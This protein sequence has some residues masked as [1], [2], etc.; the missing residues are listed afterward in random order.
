MRLRS[1]Q[2]KKFRN[3][4]DSGEIAVEEW[5]TCLVGK[6]EAGKSALLEALYLLNPAYDDTFNV[7]EQYPRWLA[8]EDRRQGDLN[9]VTPISVRLELE[10]H[11]CDEVV[12]ALGTGVLTSRDLKVSKRYGG[13]WSWSLAWSEEVAVKNL[14]G[15]F[16][17][18]VAGAVREQATLDGLKEALGAL[19]P[20]D[21][22]SGP[23]DDEIGAARAVLADKGLDTTGVW[24]RLVGIL[25]PHLPKFFRFTEYSTL[26]GRIDFEELASGRQE[27]PGRSGLQTARALLE[28][29]GTQ[30]DQLQNDDYELR[31]GELEAVQIDL[32]N[33]VFE[34]WKQNP[35]L[36]VVIDVDKET[37]QHSHGQTAVARF[38]DIRLS[39]GRTGYSNNF[40][41]R[42]SGFQWFFSFL[43]AFSEFNRH[44]APVVLLDEPAL[45]LHGRAQADFLRFI[46]QRLAPDS[47][48]LYT[49]HS[50][51]M[52]EAGSLERVRIVEDSGPPTGATATT[53]VLVA[54]PDSLFPLQAA[55]G[56][57]IA[58]SLF[59]GPNNLVV[60]GTSDFIYLTIMSQLCAAS[61]RSRLDDRWR[62]LPAG[63]ATNIPTFVSLIGPH[64]DITVLADAGTKGMQRVTGMVNQ[65]LLAGHRLILAS[66]AAVSTNADIE[67]LFSEGDYLKLFN[68]TF[69]T[70]LTVSNLPQG[71]R[72]VKRLEA[73]QGD[74]VH[75]EVAE[76]LLR[77]HSDIPF[78]DT[79]LDRFATLIDAINVTMG[80]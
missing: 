74:Y 59:I 27:G 3:V 16:P 66:A 62:V 26:P 46:N 61:G 70:S 77:K 6:N 7:E 57:D 1:F 69:N 8:V 38:L 58:Q 50:P 5:V 37:V 80:A 34:Y 68:K 40:S 20:A 31:R 13:R 15:E 48:V 9:D 53:E 30:L 12:E 39:D 60:E 41:Q 65:G 23:S 51:F 17:A 18:S 4:V 25:K 19:V 32:T 33:Q 71:D 56:Y 28:L 79:T 47:P 21:E 75:G 42:S 67:D 63:G 44:D 14:L 78:T 36:K 43:A 72:I 2:V 10:D 45:T 35:D 76:T 73:K 22:G 52:V 49:T 24:N 11:E 64:L 55:L 29:A 54:D